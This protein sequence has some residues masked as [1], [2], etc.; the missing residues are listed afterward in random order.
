MEASIK[1]G[2]FH[3]EIKKTQLETKVWIL[4]QQ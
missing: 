1:L 4:N 3:A 2:D